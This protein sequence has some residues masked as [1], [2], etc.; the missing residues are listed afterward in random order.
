M[1][2]AGERGLR[3]DHGVP[4][5]SDACVDGGETRDAIADPCDDIQYNSE[6]V[7]GVLGSRSCVYLEVTRLPDVRISL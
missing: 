1:F 5:P 7:S 2:E 3:R 4:P 6:D